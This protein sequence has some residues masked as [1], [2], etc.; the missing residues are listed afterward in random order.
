MRFLSL[1]Q[2]EPIFLGDELADAVVASVPQALWHHPQLWALVK[3]VAARGITYEEAATSLQQDATLG[4]IDLRSATFANENSA[5]AVRC[6][7]CRDP[8]AMR[9]KFRSID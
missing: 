7:R 1:S 9:A 5:E 2:A 3:M 4:E 6:F 8:S